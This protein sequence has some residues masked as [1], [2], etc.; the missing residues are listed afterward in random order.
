MA[1][2]VEVRNLR[3]RRGKKVVLDGLSLDVAAGS[4]TGLL[5]PSGSGK[6]TLIRAIVGVQI[7]EAGDVHVLG[8]PA[9]GA[10]LRPRVGYVTQAPSVY[11][12]LT[13]RENL[14]Y[15]AQILG[16]GAERVDETIDEVDLA[17]QAGQRVDRLS[18]GQ[19]ARVSLATAL[20]NRPELLVLDEPTV[21]L[22]P[23]LRRDLWQLFHSLAGAGSTLLVSSHVMDEADRCD[24]LLLLRDGN[25]LAATSPA[26]LRLQTGEQ[27]L[28]AAFLA[29]AESA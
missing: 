9:G 23:V 15:F 1:M 5:G 26:E 11:G 10:E 14:G 19:R 27:D 6:S 8:R 18:G 22:D 12:D 2:A 4:V 25:L 13:V 20:L 16:V 29:L 21:G 3:V 28:E 17:P 7:V 24:S